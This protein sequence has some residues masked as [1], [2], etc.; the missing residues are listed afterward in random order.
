MTAQQRELVKQYEHDP[1]APEPK[2]GVGDVA[3]A[4]R[5][6]VKAVTG[7]DVKRIIH[8]VAAIHADDKARV[9]QRRE[10]KRLRA[11]GVPEIEAATQAS[12]TAG[13]SGV[14]TFPWPS[15]ARAVERA[16][17]VEV[18]RIAGP[19]LK[20]AVAIARKSPAI[21]VV[22]RAVAHTTI[23][24][25]VAD[26]NAANELKQMADAHVHHAVKQLPRK[27]RQAA[28][29][30]AYQEIADTM[31]ATAKAHAAPA[32]TP[33]RLS[34]AEIT[35]ALHNALG[36]STEA[37]TVQLVDG[38]R[39]AV[40]PLHPIGN[41]EIMLL[42]GNLVD[43]KLVT[44]V[45]AG[46]GTLLAGAEKV[47][48]PVESPAVPSPREETLHA[49]VGAQRV[50]RAI[51]E[52]AAP[53]AQQA[54]MNI[55][56][57]ARRAREME[58][59]MVG[60]DGEAA[61]LAARQKMR[62]KFP[63]V[64]WGGMQ[65][66][67]PQVWNQMI[68]H[69]TGHPDLNVYEIQ[70]AHIAL[71]KLVRGQLPQPNEVTLLNR[72]F[73]K[74][75]I[76]SLRTEKTT[77]QKMKHLGLE[78]YHLPR[79]IMST[80][81]FSGPLRQMLVL[82]VRHP[83]IFGRNFMKMF[84]A[85]R[86]QEVYDQ[87]MRTIVE[88]PNYP[89]MKDRVAFTDIGEDFT[90]REE[91][92]LSNLLEKK[93]SPVKI[94]VKAANRAYVAALNLSRKD[95]F[96]AGLEK[97]ERFAQSAKG[98]RWIAKK[99]L[100]AAPGEIPD[101]L[102]DDMARFVNSATGRGSLGKSEFAKDTLKFAN[103]FLFAPRLVASRINFLNLAY[104]MSLSPPAR[105]DA[106]ESFASLLG[107]VGFILGTA[108]LGGAAVELDPRS[109]DFAKIRLGNTRIDL[110][111]GFQQ[112]VRYAAQ[113]IVAEQ[114]YPTTGELAPKSRL[115]TAGKF[116]WSKLA[117]IP[118]FAIEA[119]HGQTFVGQK[120]DVSH[121]A[122]ERMTPMFAQDMRDMIQNGSHYPA[123]AALVA[124]LSMFGAGASTYEPYDPQAR[125]RAPSTRISTVP[126]PSYGSTRRSRSSG[127]YGGGGGSYGASYGGGSPYGR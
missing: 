108:K 51:R 7:A 57:S 102:L 118:S 79:S 78:L 114:K 61:I 30:R 115:G 81:D 25:V 10:Y 62:G 87:L 20:R 36:V 26:K 9:K 55:Q 52:T 1:T 68:S 105:R 103:Y 119:M 66:L 11:Q 29:T 31:R 63:Q 59:A 77:F 43:P 89:L 47:A 13:I 86:S 112:P 32:S 18:P 60:L 80:L 73:K 16:V 90:Q 95:T 121:A 44:A 4:A 14:A 67:T 37:A 96:N 6:V 58:E 28:A 75:T 21:K 101:V 5:V 85:W 88:D 116:G 71:K 42:D 2:V 39:H 122:Y 117:P 106:L 120:F 49:E 24:E 111:G 126:P 104:Y 110:L 23:D 35:S 46:D 45:H 64:D 12:T 69:V 84:R 48:T 124:G 41:N 107:M 125:K 76:D 83:R 34:T 8:P 98:E 92:F 15:P 33:A 82:S 54:R 109:S 22:D 19:A 93:Y 17:G 100:D 113:F 94:P 50:R 123:M 40:N 3:H 91:V 65:D 97:V 53:R 27:E 99:G 70:R 56:E 72:I 38:S 74:E 127:S